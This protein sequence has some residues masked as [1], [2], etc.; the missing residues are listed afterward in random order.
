MRNNDITLCTTCVPLGP[1]SL[2]F[3]L[4]FRDNLITKIGV[5]FS[6]V[7]DRKEEGRLIVSLRRLSTQI[8]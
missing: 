5:K 6:T 7:A 4:Y 8:D 3:L 1:P 2:F